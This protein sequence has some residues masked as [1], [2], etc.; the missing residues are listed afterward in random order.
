MA[1]GAVGV[2]AAG[3]WH[4]V[5]PMVAGVAAAG[6]AATALRPLRVGS[7]CVRCGL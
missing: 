2:M 4:G 7:G 5:A 6:T 1:V 3:L